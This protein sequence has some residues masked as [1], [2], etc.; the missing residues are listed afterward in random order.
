MSTA[1]WNLDP[2]HSEL[3]FKVKHLGIS[4]VSGSFEVISGSLSSTDDTFKQA[5]ISFHADAASINTNNADRDNHLK[6]ADFFDTENFATLA[7]EAKDV[8]LTKGKIRGLLTIRGNSIPVDLEVDFEGV[9]KDPWGNEKAGF[10]VSAKIKRSE[11][12][13]TWNTALETGGLLV[14]DDVKITGEAQF[15]KNA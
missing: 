4:S 15:V 11:F 1:Q 10:S 8:D 9:A 13:L 14:G 12:G 2:S 5:T 6:S 3:R 7:F